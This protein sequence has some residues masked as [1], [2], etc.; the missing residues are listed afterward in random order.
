MNDAG[1]L[2]EPLALLSLGSN[3]GD[4]VSN[5]RKAIN[6]LTLNG[7]IADVTTS[8]FYKTEPVGYKDQPWFVNAAVLCRPLL[9]PE[10][11]LEMCKKAEDFLG[12]KSR[13]QWHEREIDIDIVLYGDLIIERKGLKIPHPRMQ[14]RSFVLLPAAEIAPDMMHPVIKCTISDLLRQCQ[15]E[16]AV[17]PLD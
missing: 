15:D 17:V 13:E 4:S 16:S 3:I 2:N 5:I 10:G 14:L 9:S 1:Q 8:G 11:L 6:L 7:S 12:R